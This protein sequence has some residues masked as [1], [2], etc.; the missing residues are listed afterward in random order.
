MVNAPA[1]VGQDW[2]LLIG[3]TRKLIIE[4]LSK[5]LHCSVDELIV[6]EQ[7]LEPR[8]I[9]RKTASYGG[10]LY[11]TASNSRYAAFLRHPNFSKQFNN[12][13]FCG[14]SVH[15]GGG[16]PLCLQSARIVADML[17]NSNT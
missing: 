3:Q 14:G 4:K 7:V 1:D 9:E 2:D 5:A 6:S 17:P 10:S 8:T 15:P 16:I 11:G 12:L 13:F